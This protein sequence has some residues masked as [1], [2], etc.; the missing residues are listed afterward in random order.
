MV[1]K[2]T[3]VEIEAGIHSKERAQVDRSKTKAQQLAQ[4]A[5]LDNSSYV[6]SN[7]IEEIDNY[8]KVEYD[9]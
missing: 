9:V 7:D 5:K 6:A 1:T 4:H 2:Q 3:S 8:K